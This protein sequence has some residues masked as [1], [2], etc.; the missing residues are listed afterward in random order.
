MCNCQTRVEENHNI[1]QLKP[2]EYSVLLK[3]TDIL[4]DDCKQK[5]EHFNPGQSALSE[6]TVV[7][8]Y[9]KQ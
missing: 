7:T 5:A 8:S 1:M 9:S 4:V 3:E 2:G 6:S